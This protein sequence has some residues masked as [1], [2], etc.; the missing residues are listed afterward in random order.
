MKTLLC[1]VAVA[2]THAL[3]LP[4]SAAPQQAASAAAHPASMDELQRQI[5]ELKAAFAAFKETN[6]GLAES[7]SNTSSTVLP[8]GSI[9]AF[10]GQVEGIPDNW[11]LCDGKS[12]SSADYPLLWNRIGTVWGGSGEQSF[13]LP[14]LR[15]RFLRGVDGGSNRDPDAAQRDPNGKGDKNAVGSTQEDAIQAHRHVDAGHDHPIS[16]IST[17][18][19]H[20]YF[21]CGNSCGALTGGGT[22]SI[23]TGKA[24]IGDPTPSENSTVRVASETRV[25]NVYVFWIIRV[26]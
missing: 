1:V 5:D 17:Y 8:V 22:V 20:D 26:K 13:K 19:Y 12:V 23:G 4:G 9:V 11:K 15:A 25:K 21:A 10:A 2:L 7:L 24:N 14:D 6:T 18:G 16:G 3:C